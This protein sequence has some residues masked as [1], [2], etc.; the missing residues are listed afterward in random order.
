M[1][2]FT[3]VLLIAMSVAILVSTILPALG[4]Q[5]SPAEIEDD[6]MQIHFERSGGFAGLRLAMALDEQSLTPQEARKLKELI[7]AVDFYA[8]PASHRV[9]SRYRSVSV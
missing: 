9:A 1:P 2:A 3:W 5:L 8:S 7:E 6:P 4:A